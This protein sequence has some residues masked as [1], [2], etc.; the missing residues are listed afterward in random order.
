[1]HDPPLVHVIH[2]RENL[3]Y[4]VDDE[5]VGEGE[6]R[7]PIPGDPVACAVL[8]ELHP[9]EEGEEFPAHTAL[10]HHVHLARRLEDVEELDDAGVVNPTQ[11]RDLAPQPLYKNLVVV[12]D[13]DH[14]NREQLPGRQVLSRVHHRERPHP[15]NLADVAD[16][17]E[18]LAL[19]VLCV[20][21][22]RRP[23][24]LMRVRAFS[25]GHRILLVRVRV[26]VHV[27][28]LAHRNAVQRRFC[29]AP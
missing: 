10:H 3:V 24:N 15:N 18:P 28:R 17:V 9:L 21:V 7:T 12:G 22:L 23:Q 2:R 19:H 1:M 16:L 8:L 11:D 20:G 26:H 4:D 6:R 29:L 27:G 5:I 13:L 25:P 14:F